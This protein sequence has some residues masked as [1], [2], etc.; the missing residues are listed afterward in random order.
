[1]QYIVLYIE[2]QFKYCI[3]IILRLIIYDLINLMLSGA[4]AVRERKEARQ[5]K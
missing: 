4:G 5:D 1:M 2:M 3:V